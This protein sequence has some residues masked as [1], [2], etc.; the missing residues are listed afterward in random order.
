MDRLVRPGRWAFG[1]GLVGFGVLQFIFGDFIPGRAPAW[2]S[3]VPGRLLFAYGTGA[4]LILA[5]AAIIVEMRA[6]QAA[7]LTGT[8]IFCWALSWL[9]L[10]TILREA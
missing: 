5:G 6:R 8:L 3:A 1:L 10:S 2:P 4:L 7:M 9:Y